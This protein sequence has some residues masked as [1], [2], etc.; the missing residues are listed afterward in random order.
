[1]KLTH[2]ANRD[3]THANNTLILAGKNLATSPTGTTEIWITG[4]GSK[5][6]TGINGN[7]WVIRTPDGTWHKRTPGP[8]GQRGQHKP[9]EQGR[10]TTQTE[11][12]TKEQTQ[13]LEAARTKA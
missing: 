7:T 10:W 13:V 12:T 5:A 3:A 4:A 1:M 11:P 6:A 8:S 2:Y 9:D